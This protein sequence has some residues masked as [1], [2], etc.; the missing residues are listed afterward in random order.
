MATQE[1]TLSDLQQ[2][3]QELLSEIQHLIKDQQ[4]SALPRWVKSKDILQILNVSP[5]TLQRMRANGE[6]P[7]TKI[8][9]CIFYD[10]EEINQRLASRQKNNANIL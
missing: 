8:N 3:K 9:R 5:G 1:I 7:F 10:L 6:L 2:F 4:P